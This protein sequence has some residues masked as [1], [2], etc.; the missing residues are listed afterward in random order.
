L[1]RVFCWSASESFLT[2]PVRDLVNQV[3]LDARKRPSIADGRT[4]LRDDAGQFHLAADGDCHATIFKNVTVQ[5]NLCRLFG[6]N[7]TRQTAEGRQRCISRIPRTDPAF[8]IQM[9]WINEYEPAIMPRCPPLRF[10]FV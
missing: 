5:I 6:K 2:G 8:R 4:A 3:L 10:A 9:K 1:P 7:A